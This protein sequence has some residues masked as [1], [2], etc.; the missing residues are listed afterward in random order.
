MDEYD[1]ITVYYP[2]ETETTYPADTTNEEIAIDSEAYQTVF[3]PD[4]AI[5]ESENTIRIP[6]GVSVT[7][8]QIDD[9]VAKVGGK[10]G[11]WVAQKVGG[12][13]ILTRNQSGIG[14]MN[15]KDLLMP[16]AIIGGLFLL[17]KG[18]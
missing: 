4:I 13:T 7:Q 8:K 18:K 15:V 12:Q 11:N 10:V 3:G 9:I 1:E 16:A 6:S 14:T 2:D 17:T 5:K